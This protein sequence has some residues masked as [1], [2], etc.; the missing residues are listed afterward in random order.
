[1]VLILSKIGE[2]IN[3]LGNSTTTAHI[4]ISYDNIYYDYLG[5][6][7]NNTTMFDLDNI[8]YTHKVTYIK[9]DFFGDTRDGINIVNIFGAINSL[10]YPSFGYYITLPNDNYYDGY[11][12]NDC[13]YYFDCY[14]RCYYS[15]ENYD[16]ED[17]CM[18]GCDLA[19]F[20]NRNNCNNY[21]S[22]SSDIEFYGDNGDVA[23]LISSSGNSMNMVNA[24]KRSKEF[25]LKVV[26]FTGFESTNNLKKEG[27]LNFW[28]NSKAYNIV[29]MV[30]HI[31]LLS[32]VDSIIG[33]PFYSA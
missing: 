14:T 19:E 33:S 3:I 28:V 5:I 10:S 2:S 31:W 15:N 30:H 6:L 13:H 27:D 7:D 25:G 18:V 8:N 9:L 23:V 17:S 20:T 24:A 4:S 26:T 1:M 21:D 12:I 11:F 22:N 32:I 29:E 16:S